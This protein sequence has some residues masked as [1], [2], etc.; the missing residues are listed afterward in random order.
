MS[1]VL[2]PNDIINYLPLSYRDFI[3]FSK[4][5]KS[6]NKNINVLFIGVINNDHEYFKKILTSSKYN[7][8]K[9]VLEKCKKRKSEIPQELILNSICNRLYLKS[10]LSSKEYRDIE[11]LLRNITSFNG[12][13]WKIIKNIIVTLSNLYEYCFIELRVEYTHYYITVYNT[14]LT[15]I[16]RIMTSMDLEEFVVMIDNNIGILDFNFKLLHRI[17]IEN[18]E[19]DT[20]KQYKLFMKKLNEEWNRYNTQGIDITNRLRLLS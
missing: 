19:E 14:I 12:I 6:L 17:I 20:I 4:C 16:L 8:I 7:K 18:N 3:S 2:L 11:L 10:M 13:L 5:N 9:E 1:I 15:S